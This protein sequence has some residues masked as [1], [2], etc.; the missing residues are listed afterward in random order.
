MEPGV[1]LDEVFETRLLLPNPLACFVSAHDR[2]VKVENDN[3]EGLRLL[4]SAEVAFY[5]SE[6]VHCC[7]HLE[8]ALLQNASDDKELELVVV[9]D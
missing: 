2:H 5:G 1:Y 9:G 3:I 7:D 8:P 6:P 4:F